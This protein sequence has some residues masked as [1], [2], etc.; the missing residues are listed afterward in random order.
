MYREASRIRV[1]GWSFGWRHL[2]QR[3]RWAPPCPEALIWTAHE[4]GRVMG[5]IAWSGRA[6]E[7]AE[8]GQFIFDDAHDGAEQKVLQFRI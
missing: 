4:L 5:P 8:R 7:K 2:A 6:T 3:P 1:K